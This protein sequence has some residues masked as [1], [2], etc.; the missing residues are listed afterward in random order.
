METGIIKEER[1]NYVAPQLH[2]CTIFITL[3]IANRHH[4]FHDTTSLTAVW[5]SA[6]KG[7]AKYQGDQMQDWGFK[8]VLEISNHAL[9]NSLY[10]CY[11]KE[12]VICLLLGMILSL[13][14]SFFQIKASSEGAL[15]SSSFHVALTIGILSHLEHIIFHAR[16]GLRPQVGQLSHVLRSLKITFFSF[17]AAETIVT[18]SVG[19]LVRDMEYPMIVWGER[20]ASAYHADILYLPL[21]QGLSQQP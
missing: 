2:R 8:R 7:K 18:R 21:F 9:E 20:G 11:S 3:A 6:I 15:V 5:D 10:L 13:F 17:I 16:T 12:P 1:K 19:G 4:C 14:G